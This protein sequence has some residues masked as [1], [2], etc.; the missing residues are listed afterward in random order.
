[1]CHKRGAA[2]NSAGQPGAKITWHVGAVKRKAPRLQLL[3]AKGGH[4]VEAAGAEGRDIAG[5]AGYE[6][7]CGGGEA[8]R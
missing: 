1:V 2:A 5:G 7:E 4:G 6:G 3:V 8:Q